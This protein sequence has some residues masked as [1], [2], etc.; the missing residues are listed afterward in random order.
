[1]DP[2]VEKPHDLGLVC[3]VGQCWSVLVN[4]EYKSMHELRKMAVSTRS[5]SDTSRKIRAW[6]QRRP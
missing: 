6:V 1:M 4:T 2:R 3:E 5:M